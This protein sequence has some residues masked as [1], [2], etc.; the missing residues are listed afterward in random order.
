MKNASENKQV[1]PVIDKKKKELS[2]LESLFNYR[3]KR[4]KRLK[5]SL[6]LA[7]KQIHTFHQEASATLIP[8]NKQMAEKQVVLVK[9]LV[10]VFDD[11][12][13][14]GKEQ[15]EKLE[16]LFLFFLEDL[17][18]EKEQEGLDELYERFAEKTI[19]ETEEEAEQEEKE[20]LIMMMDMMGVGL[21]EEEKEKL[22]NGEEEENAELLEE[23]ERKLSDENFEAHKQSFF[24]NFGFQEHKKSQKQLEREEEKNKELENISKTVRQV[25]KELMKEL[26]PDKE[27]DEIKRLEKTSLV[28]EITEA[29]RNDDLFTLLSIQLTQIDE[30]D[31]KEL[32][33]DKVTYF[34]TMLLNQARELEEQKT[35]MGMEAGL[36]RPLI[37]SLGKKDFDTFAKRIIREQT[38]VAKNDL[39]E[40]NIQIKNVESRNKRYIKAFVEDNYENLI[41]RPPFDFSMLSEIFR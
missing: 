7:N 6:N 14:K 33:E 24:E 36:P 16:E 20:K 35:Q 3:I 25:Y 1:V 10:E 5:D 27:L 34:N 30:A 19:K 12:V 2:K 8:L 15:R 9:A 21:S 32:S 41:E 23:L 18:F 37:N 31:N 26:H 28:Q 22:L 13:I 4:V 38:K 29:Y 39:K 40:V 11:K 17:I